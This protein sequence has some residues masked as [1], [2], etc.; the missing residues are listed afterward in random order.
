MKTIVYMNN[1][2]SILY[3][4]AIDFLKLTYSQKVNL[5]ME[6][7]LIT[8][9]N[10]YDSEEEIEQTIFKNIKKH[11]KITEFMSEVYRINREFKS[12]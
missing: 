6:L 10:L 4:V 11:N 3:F 9:A 2:A 5:G 8:T 1:L 12:S 7:D